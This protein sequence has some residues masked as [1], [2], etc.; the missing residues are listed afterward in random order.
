MEIFGTII[1]VRKYSTEKEPGILHIQN[2]K[3]DKK[4]NIK[5]N[6]FLPAHNLD[7]VKGFVD[8]EN[9]FIYKPLVI[10]VETYDYL[11]QSLFA[12]LRKTKFSSKKCNDFLQELIEYSENIE[13]VYKEL[14]SWASD[15][16]KRNFTSTVLTFDQID[17]FLNW[18]KKNYLLR[19]LYLLG[20]GDSEIKN[21]YLDYNTI[22]QTL[23]NNPYSLHSISESKAENICNLLEKKSNNQDILGG[24][25]LRFIY[26]CGWTSIPLPYITK[27]FPELY[28]CLDYIK[29]KF[30]IV[31]D[32]K[33][34]YCDY[35]Y[36]METFLADKI[37]N[38][39]LKKIN[40]DL[41][42]I[43]LPKVVNNIVKLDDIVLTDE[44]EK[45]L[46][47][48]LENHISIISGGAGCG[49]TT[50]IKNIIKNLE[51]R[52]IKYALTSFTG[53]AVLRIKEVLGEEYSQHCYTLSLLIQKKKYNIDPP[54]F[55]TLIIDEA[56]MISGSLI[57]DFLTLYKRYYK[58]ILVGDYNQLPPIGY[59]NFFKELILS[60]KVNTY[61]LTVNK[62]IIDNVK[63]SNILQNANML[64]SQEDKKFK[65]GNGFELLEGD[66]NLVNKIIASLYKHNVKFNDI[67]V[68]TPFNKDIQSINDYARKIFLK[69]SEIFEYDNRQFVVGDRLMQTVNV[70]NE[71]TVVMNGEEGNIR[72]IDKN[73]LTI[74]YNKDKIIE[75]KWCHDKKLTKKEKS[76]NEEEKSEKEF[77]SCDLKHSFTKTVHKSQGSEYLYVIFYLPKATN[78]S[79]FVNINLLYTAITRA[80]KTIWLVCDKNSLYK[81]LNTNIK[82]QF[83]R[84][85]FRLKD[86]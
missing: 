1:K 10:P 22:Y 32:D 67:T 71:E 73:G 28:S 50:L 58:I 48:C 8:E 39:I 33:Y 64:I 54:K 76:E 65:T 30:P 20:L 62:R 53:K 7:A 4:Y 6:G 77:F 19:K 82:E 25:I 47:G 51:Y 57:Y 14:N 52:N 11:Q 21:S 59:C 12:C 15:K 31:F 80:K 45:A 43:D 75:Y 16:S 40:E 23:K 5:F 74:F 3:D 63:S 27:N 18:W 13:N 69:D 38:M 66:H 55:E 41:L 56:S 79:D 24:K 26:K 83:D 68:L 29:E 72:S 61:Y 36:Q 35:C 60:N 17:K 85:S 34:V 2:I 37:N 42:N 49:K 78:N 86:L 70:Y 46:E 81:A 44:Q 84:L 9:S